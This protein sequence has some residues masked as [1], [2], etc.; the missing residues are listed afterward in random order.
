VGLLAI[1]IVVAIVALA[2][3]SAIRQY[4][5]GG[6]SKRSAP[7]SPAGETVGGLAPATPDGTAPAP[8]DAVE[9]ARALEDAIKQQAADYEKRIDAQSK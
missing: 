3:G 2:A 9:R 7:V 1:L 4:G 6:A 8:R 5:L